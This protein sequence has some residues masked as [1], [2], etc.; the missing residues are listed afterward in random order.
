[1]T[2]KIQLERNNQFEDQYHPPSYQSLYGFMDG[3]QMDLY[4]GIGAIQPAGNSPGVAATGPVAVTT[5]AAAPSTIKASAVTATSAVAATAEASSA[6]TEA[7]TT[8]KASE[9]TTEASAT[10]KASEA[11]A[12][13]AAANTASPCNEDVPTYSIKNMPAPGTTK[14]STSSIKAVDTSPAVVVASTLNLHTTF[15]LAPPMTTA[16]AA[17]AAASPSH[18]CKRKRGSAKAKRGCVIIAYM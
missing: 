9:A 11:T 1:V 10:T 15:K 14:V 16:A 4:D 18:R 2:N 8:T 6:T 17:A 5:S 13:V 7:S 3:A 12:S